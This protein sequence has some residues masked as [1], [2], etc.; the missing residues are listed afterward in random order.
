MQEILSFTLSN[1]KMYS[2][3]LLP[4]TDLKK[5]AARAVRL[6]TSPLENAF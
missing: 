1:V 2:Y 6:L 3:L 5:E 4:T